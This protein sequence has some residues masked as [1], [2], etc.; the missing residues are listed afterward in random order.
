MKNRFPRMELLAGIYPT[1]RMK[2]FVSEVY[3]AVIEFARAAVF[4]FYTSG[5][6][7]MFSGICGSRG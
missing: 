2:R 7:R 3:Q 1:L 4:Y 6:T 5:T